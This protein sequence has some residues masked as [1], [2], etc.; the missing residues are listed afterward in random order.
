MLWHPVFRKVRNFNHA[1][2]SD[3]YN[4]PDSQ[5]LS[6]SQILRAL[7]PTLADKRLKLLNEQ[8]RGVAGET[9]WMIAGF[10][11]EEHQ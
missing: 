6:D 1:Y 8:E 4:L 9:A 7:A 11:L 2:L 3:S 10:K 5:I